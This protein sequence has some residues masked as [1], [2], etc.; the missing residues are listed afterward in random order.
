MIITSP[1]IIF[2]KIMLYNLLKYDI[3]IMAEKYSKFNQWLTS[4]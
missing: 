3:F 4:G 1:K 2:S